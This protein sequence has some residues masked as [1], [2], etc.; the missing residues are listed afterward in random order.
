MADSES[1]Y[2]V[3]PGRPLLRTRFKKGQSCNLGA[4]ILPVLL[5]MR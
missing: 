5:P 4:R 3:S 2:E 1:G